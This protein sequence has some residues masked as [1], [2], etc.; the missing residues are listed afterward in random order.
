[1]S[2]SYHEAQETPGPDVTVW[3]PPPIYRLPDAAPSALLF[4]FAPLRPLAN[5]ICVQLALYAVLCVIIIGNALLPL[6]SPSLGAGLKG[7]RVLLLLTTGVCFLVWTYRL[8]QNLRAF[9]VSR[10]S[11]T[12]GWAVGYFF[13]PIISLYRPYQIFSEIWKASDPGPAPREGG[14]WQTLKVPALVGVWWAFWL[15]SGIVDQLSATTP[16]ETTGVALGA[17]LRL[18]AAVL[19]LLVVRQFTAREEQTAGQL[20]L[21]A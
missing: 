9:G 11:V 14:A 19:A 4:R 2:E 20:S 5:A 8:H 10:L 18:I 1:M 13:V 12:A 16:D 17:A 21:I 6:G 15:G 7:L 3:P